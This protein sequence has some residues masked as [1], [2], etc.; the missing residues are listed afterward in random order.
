MN[1]QYVQGVPN[2]KKK[3]LLDEYDWYNHVFLPFSGRVSDN[4]STVERTESKGGQE[5]VSQLSCDTLW[6]SW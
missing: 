2:G 4:V 1:K 6:G 3:G 5:W